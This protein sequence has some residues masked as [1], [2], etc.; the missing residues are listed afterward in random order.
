MAHIGIIRTP[1]GF[2]N[3]FAPSGLVL[4]RSA[5]GGTCV[6]LRM[7]PSMPLAIVGTLVMAL[8]LF[9]AINVLLQGGIALGAMLGLGVT[10]V[11][12]GVKSVVNYSA[13]RETYLS[14]LRRTLL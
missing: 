6:E 5:S 4:L 8:V 12:L 7:I 14:F 1:D 13:Y 3:A 2:W 11:G 10:I 9:V